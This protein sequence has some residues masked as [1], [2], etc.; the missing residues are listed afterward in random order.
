MFKAGVLKV[1]ETTDEYLRFPPDSAN[2]N[3]P[4]VRIAATSEQ[5]ENLR[6]GSHQAPN[7]DPT[8]TDRP[9]AAPVAEKGRRRVSDSTRAIVLALYKSGLP[10]AQIAERTGVSNS[11]VYLILVTAGVVRNRKTA[12]DGEAVAD[13]LAVAPAGDGEA[14]ADTLAVAPAGEAGPEPVAVAVAPAGDGE[15]VADTLA[16]APAGEAGP[17]PVAV[18]VAPAGEAGPNFGLGIGG[19]LDLLRAMIEDLRG[20]GVV[21]GPVD[22]WLKI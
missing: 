18:A 19:R 22:V 1:S 7:R 17:E 9:E 4:P 10:V 6:R 5:M 14:V 11:G 20:R 8:V 12:G 16:V 13:T 15:A 2:R 21:I 3:G